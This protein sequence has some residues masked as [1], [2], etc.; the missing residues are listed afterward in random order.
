VLRKNNQVPIDIATTSNSNSNS[1]SSSS[2]SSSSNSN[3]N[4]SSS[5]RK[6]SATRQ[7]GTSDSIMDLQMT[8]D[9]AVAAMAG[10]AVLGTATMVK[11]AVNGN[12]LGISGI[13]NGICGTL[14]SRSSSPWYWRAVFTLGFLAAGMVLRA[15]AP[16][17]LQ[18]LPTSMSWARIVLAGALV[19][20]GTSMGNGCTSGHG[21]SGLTRLSKR[22]VVATATFMTSAACTASITATSGYFPTATADAPI[23]SATVAI[24]SSLVLLGVL[25]TFVGVLSTAVGPK[26]AAAAADSADHP[27]RLATEFMAAMSFG[28]ALGISGMGRAQQVA[29]FLD[30]HD[31]VWDPTLALVMGGALAVTLPLYHLHVKTMIP[32]LNIKLEIPSRT[33]I[34]LNLVVG[35]GLFGAGWG[36]C[37]VCPGPA[38]INVFAPGAMVWQS[39]N[40]AF[41]AA[42]LGGA[43]VEQ[44]IKQ[45]RNDRKIACMQCA[46]EEAMPPAADQEADAEAPATSKDCTAAETVAPNP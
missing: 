4:S 2:S 31:G 43:L 29:A 1:N 25:G 13:V 19:G 36:L 15:V 12:I 32:V 38:L 46:D 24:A 28:L 10:G 39:R 34:D 20:L 30:V 11:L 44:L 40:G 37:G 8:M 3:S 9:G 22:S 16:E 7:C 14:V 21:I 42:M 27:A 41:I 33:D 45:W 6:N 5:V 26:T 35:A 23:V 18:A 17:A